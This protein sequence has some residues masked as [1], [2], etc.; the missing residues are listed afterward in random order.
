MRLRLHGIIPPIVTPFEADGDVAE[1]ELRAEVRYHLYLGVHGICTAGSTGEGHT[2]SREEAA[3]VA[4][5]VV[6]EVAG[7][8]PVIAGIIRDSTRD[9]IDYGL[10]LRETGVDALQITPVHYLFT[11]DGDETFAYYRTITEAVGLPVVI[12]N[13]VP[14][15]TIEPVTLARI[16]NEV[17]L[18]V[19]VK[20]S[21]G[22]IHRLADLI[23]LRPHGGAVLTA[24]DDLLYPT[25]MLGAQGAIA[26]TLTVAPELCLQ[27]WDAVQVGDH[28][29]ALSLHERLLPVWRAIDA[30][31]MPALIKYALSLQG[32]AGGVSR[33]PMTPVSADQA[34]R[35][36]AA[37]ADAGIGPRG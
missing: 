24:I 19:G 5:L 17:D 31:N 23:R 14:W 37:L 26:A 10:A 35:V 6:D 21:G 30:P 4:R 22:D 33:R 2:L 3:A 34:T 36:Q 29:A 15:S 13:V 18:V 32:R 27:L 8:V 1:D 9:V 16:L 7:R 20:Q 25:L 12:Y 11:P 28:K